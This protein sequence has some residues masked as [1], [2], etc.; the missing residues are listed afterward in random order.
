MIARIEHPFDPIFDSESK[1]LFVG[2]IASTKSRELG[3]PYASP[4]NRFW[5]VLGKIF[6]E[7]IEDHREFLLKH[8]IALWDSIKSCDITASSDASIKNIEVNE[9]WEIT[10]NA[11]IKKVFANGQKAFN[12][13]KKY[14]YPRT[15]VEA[16]CLPSTSPANAS[17]SLDNLV[18]DYKIILQYL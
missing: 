6:D 12:V 7:K 1:I 4:Q 17:K 11:D 13:Y 10:E 15:K 16:V 3:F 2:S 18:E 5:K 9:L 14:I 8:N